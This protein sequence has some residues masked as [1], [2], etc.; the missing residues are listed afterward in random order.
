MP[1]THRILVC[2][3]AAFLVACT[4]QSLPSF[5]NP[6]PIT[7]PSGKPAY[8]PR[9]SQ[10]GGEGAV[11][12][13][14]ERND[15]GGLL[16]YS[17]LDQ[18]TWQ[19][20][21]TVINDKDMFVNWAD[22]PAV[23]PLGGGALLAHWLSYVADSPYA[24]QILTAVS[25]DAGSTWSTPSSPHS[26]GTPTEHGFL[27]TYPAGDGVG[28]IWLDGRETPQAGM[29]LRNAILNTD[30][31]LSNESLI[32]DLVCDCCQ[33]DV[34]I[35]D[36]GPVAVYRN[37]TSDEVRDIYVSRYLDETWQAGTPVSDDGW[38]ISGCPVNGPSIAAKGDRVAIAWFT[39][40]NNKPTVK[41]A[42]SSNAGKSF[43]KPVEIASKGTSGHVGITLIDKHSYVVSWMEADK[44][45]GYEVNL[46]ARTADGQMGRVQT[47]GR[48]SVARNV[49]QMKLVGDN[50]ILA[51]TD[52]LSDLSK[53]VSVKVPILGFYD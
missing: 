52:E 4:E 47:V 22:L 25:M 43:S 8:G 37:R 21:A 49:P 34:A 50:L 33:T 15:D 30:G 1:S 38:E 7:V 40:A 28:L 13:W 26:D 17:I 14:M 19:P 31:S 9:L 2:V 3:L 51:W 53:V 16:R 23:T 36:T 42:F 20:A 5:K 35:T 46:R 6:Q 12:S 41:T 24:Y 10:G 39:A 32:D 27:S 44:D 29:T 18:G 11:L 48:T 45:G